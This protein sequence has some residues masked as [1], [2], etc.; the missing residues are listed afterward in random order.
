MKEEMFML[1][2]AV[3]SAEVR[4]NFSQTVDD[5][6]Y[7]APKFV[8]RHKRDLFLMMNPEHLSNL[9]SDFQF[10]AEIEQDELGE[11]IATLEEFEDFFVTGQTQNEAIVNLAKELVEYASDYLQDR[12]S[13]Y[14]HAPNRKAHFPYLVKVMLQNSIEDVVKLIHVK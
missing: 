2:I 8:T 12:F 14:Y 4:K 7:K 1:Q 10:H 6:L 11:Y 9:L 3:D 13:V 5:V